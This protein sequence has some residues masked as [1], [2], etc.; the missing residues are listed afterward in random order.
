[1]FSEVDLHQICKPDDTIA[2]T[3]IKSQQ[4][5]CDIS[6]ETSGVISIETS[7]TTFLLNHPYWNDHIQPVIEGTIA[8]I[9]EER[10]LEPIEGTIVSNALD[11]KI[12]F[13][14][15]VLEQQQEIK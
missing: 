6:F 8:L 15:V 12:Y 7:S 14:I 10:S 13:I 1:V 4:K 11:D 9:S 3:N 5:S 2:N